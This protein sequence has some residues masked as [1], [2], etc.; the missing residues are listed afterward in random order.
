MGMV[1]RDIKPANLLVQGVGGGDGRPARCVVKILDFG[2]A[3][4]KSHGRPGSAGSS[5]ETQQNM[6]VGTP[7]YLS[8]EQAK[9]LRRRTSAAACIVWAARFTFC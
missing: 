7:D 4:F 3:G 1:H 6:V 2:A 9:N 5:I 8:P